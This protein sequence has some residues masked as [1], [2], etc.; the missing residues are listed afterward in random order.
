MFNRFAIFTSMF[1]CALP[2]SAVWAAEDDS[3][4]GTVLEV[5][6]S[7]TITSEGQKDVMAA[8][9]SP[10]HINDIIK[11][12]PGARAYILMIDD[13][14]WTLSEDAEMKVDD[15]V[16]DPDDNA[17]NRE[18]YSILS[19]AFL[20]VSGLIAKKPEPDVSIETPVGSLGIRGT[21]F[22]GGDIDGAYGVLVN[23]GRVRFK[24][25]AGEV[26]LNKGEG[27]SVRARRL[28]PDAAKVWG[29]DKIDRAT[30]TVFLK[31]QEMVMQRKAAMKDRQ[32]QLRDRFKEHVRKKRDF[33]QQKRPPDMRERPQAAPA[34][35]QKMQKNFQQN[36]MRDRRDSPGEFRR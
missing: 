27:T 19:G 7:V 5:E 36:K 16:F 9:D 26:L 28:P 32:I 13:T 21:E 15:Y 1:L 2:L 11:T 14:Q 23:E 34:Q 3:I 30:R 6:G 31:R 20:Y 33:L 8:V 17:A 4:I 35:R 22:W 18:V 25:D 10:V 12:G 29:R 24:N